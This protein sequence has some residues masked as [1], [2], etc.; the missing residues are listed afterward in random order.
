MA[1]LFMNACQEALLAHYVYQWG[2]QPAVLATQRPSVRLVPAT[3]RALE[4]APAPAR[5]M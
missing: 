1:P 4:F 2:V 5:T 3:F